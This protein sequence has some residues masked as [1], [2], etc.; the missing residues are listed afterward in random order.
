MLPFF[1]YF[2]GKWRSAPRY[3]SPVNEYIIEPFAGAAGY[4]TRYPDRKVMLIDSDPTIAGLW[5]YLIAVP[6][7][8]ILAIPIGIGHVDDLGNVAK[9]AKH[10]VGFWMNK[11]TSA[12]C[13]TP[14]KWMREG[15]HV[16]SFWGE[17]IRT[18][19]ANQVERIR[20][21]KI[22]E[23]D[24]RQSPVHA[25]V[26]Y[27]IDPPYSTK[28]GRNYRHNKI[29]YACLGE[30]CNGLP[31]QVIVCE[32]E[33]ADWM[34]FRPFGSFKSLEGKH[35]HCRTSEVIWTKP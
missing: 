24:Y 5:R 22:I 7:S 8:E 34:P 1:C 13:K 18:R 19:I 31:G 2:G 17:T 11:G 4:A 21:W 15:K 14:S 25:K 16:N 32:Q 30:W 29:D 28:A 35:G 6:K 26:T 33:G 12:P 10:L 23:G 27:F 20:H 3:P 9:E